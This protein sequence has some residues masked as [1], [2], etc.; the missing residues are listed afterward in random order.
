M[1]LVRL[2][3]LSTPSAEAKRRRAGRGQNVIG[4]GEIVT[5]GF[6]SIVAKEIGP[7]M[8]DFAQTRPGVLDLELQVFRSN[9]VGQFDGRVEVRRP[10]KRPRIC[11]RFPGDFVSGELLQLPAET[12]PGL[13]GQERFRL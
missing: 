4:P 1:T 6:R 2:R 13:F 7:G 10:G 9:P 12:L 11:K 8:S 3:K 5:H